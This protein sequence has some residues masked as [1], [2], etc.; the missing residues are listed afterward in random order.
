MTKE[1]RIVDIVGVGALGSHVAQ[2]LR[3]ED[4]YLTLIDFD[5]VESKNTSAQFYSK[6]GVG[7]HKVSALIE[8]MNFLWGNKPVGISHRLTTDNVYNV[9][10]NNPD[11]LIID[12]LD[13][14]A[15]RTLVQ[16]H[17]RRYGQ[18]C[19]HGALAADGAFGLVAWDKDFKVDTEDGGAAT[20][21]GGEHLPFIGVVSTMLAYSVQTFLKTG[22][23][24]G[25]SISP[26]G[27]NRI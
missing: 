12:C 9:L 18:K 20:C 4:T 1:K 17:V 3:N 15:S 21:E 13:N 26:G 16:E 19:I 5:R 8:M 7:K 22:K 11:T 14:A 2:F 25:F 23:Q 24:I 6:K 27:I 10:G